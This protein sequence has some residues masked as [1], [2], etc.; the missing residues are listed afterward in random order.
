MEESSSI[1]Y[2]SWLSSE[3]LPRFSP[4]GS[5]LQSA[6][7]MSL[8]LA[9]PLSHLSSWCPRFSLPLVLGRQRIA[10]AD[11]SPSQ[12]RGSSKHRRKSWSFLSHLEEGVLGRPFLSIAGCILWK[13]R[14]SSS[15]F[16]EG[17]T[18]LV[19]FVSWNHTRLRR[20]LPI[21]SNGRS[22]SA[23]NTIRLRAPSRCLGKSGSTMVYCPR[24]APFFDSTSADESLV[25]ASRFQ[26]LLIG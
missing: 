10:I 17:Q 2:C 8:G 6:Q 14:R 5:S 23:V 18:G 12:S 22:S 24:T 25:L 20:C 11:L 13:S 1:S 4:W 21:P 3:F 15:P 9:C 26:Y 19:L 16:S 7:L